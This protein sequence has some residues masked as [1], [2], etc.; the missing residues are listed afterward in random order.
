QVTIGAS[1]TL[2][3]KGTVA[4]ITNTLGGV[5]APGSSPAILTSS[6]VTFSGASSDFT[7]ELDG[8]NPG[9]GYDQLNVLGAVSLGGATLNVVPGFSPLDA[10]S[11]GATFTIINNDGADA[12]VGTFAGLANNAIFTNGGLK[13]RINYAA[14]DG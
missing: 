2:G 8:T 7:V 4:N 5:V 6:N 11:Q 12:I 3:G 13:F 10:P 1:G 14:G 9:S